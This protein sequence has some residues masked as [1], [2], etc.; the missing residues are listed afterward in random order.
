MSRRKRYTWREEERDRLGAVKR[1]TREEKTAGERA[2]GLRGRCQ[3]RWPEGGHERTGEGRKK[4][5]WSQTMCAVLIQ[6]SSIS[7]S[8]LIKK[9]KGGIDLYALY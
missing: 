2:R 7:S 9:S 4:K 5:T 3:R 6:D 1:D 8:F